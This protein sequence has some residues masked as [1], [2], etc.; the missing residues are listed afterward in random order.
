MNME[1][2]TFYITT[3]IYYPSDKLHIG[4]AYCTV[5]ADVMGRYKRQRGY[6][7]MFLTGTDEHGQK[8][9]EKAAETNVTPKQYVDK[10]V[11]GIYDLWKLMDIQYD[12]FI[13]T[14]DDYHEESVQKI[15]KTLYEK[16]AIYKGAYKGKYCTPCESFW[17]ESQLVDGKCPDCGGDVAYAE[18]EAYFF[19]LSEYGDK[20]MKFYYEENPTFLQPVSRLNEMVN[21][22]IKPGLEDLCVSRN[23]VKWGVPVDFDP[24]HVVYVWIDALSNYIT[25]LGYGNDKYDDY[26][27]YWPADVHFVGKE[28]TRFHTIIWPAILMALE[29]PLPKKVYG[30]GWLLLDGGKMSKSKGNVVDPVIL[31]ERYG[32]DALRYFLLREFPF[33]SDGLFSNE[34]LI[35][36]INIDLANDLGNL[37]SRSLTMV[38]KYFGEKIPTNRVSAEI[39]NEFIALI[40][41]LRGD[42]EKEMEQYAFQNA[43]ANVFKLISRA[44][45]YIDETAPWVLGKNEEDH[46]RLAAVLYNLVEVVRISAIL[47]TPFMPTSCEAILAQLK[48]DSSLTT[49]EKAEYISDIDY[50][51]VKGDNL[52][53]R[54]D[55]KKEL[56]ALSPAQ[57][58][59]KP[60]KEEKK[61]QKEE[62]KKQEEPL[63][64]GIITID[65][66]M[67]VSLK[68]AKIESCE[69]VPKSDKLLCLQLNDGSDKLRQV[70][71]GI[72]TW[73]TPEQLVGKKVC[74]VANL[75]PAK[76]RGVESNG[77]ILA[78]D[79][80]KE[81]G[82]ED[83]KVIFIDES[84][85]VGS[86]IR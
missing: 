60:A 76:L 64:D 21:N 65:S 22:F 29:L 71:S 6:D 73:Y 83:V 34:L 62:K 42:F 69:P 23:T 9:E 50:T 80:Q 36:R 52:F 51:I 19:K 5:A 38:N 45:K 84:V 20:L 15:F 54:L 17:T 44:N 27:K 24:G 55:L 37:V 41:E 46:P 66:F 63:A 81:D 26:D 75:K 79:S 32:V 14:T 18:E 57:P 48:V 86:K 11:E 16:G 13:R 77:M 72:A 43:L 7:V 33:G 8:I 68:V 1:N 3:P 58:E 35:H 82:S 30:H 47:L 74:V 31:A 49:F 85:P 28:I 59:E 78:A 25:A 2:K 70:V 39:D 10:I 40:N 67:A 56:E 53:P 61:K 12:R 4:H